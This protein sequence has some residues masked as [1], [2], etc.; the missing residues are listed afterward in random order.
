MTAP[1]LLRTERLT[2]RPFQDSD[3]E[4]ALS[5]R[6]DPEFARFLPHIPQ[7]FTRRDADRET[8][9]AAEHSAQPEML[10]DTRTPVCA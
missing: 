4:D 10:N 2:L 1:I 5:Y 6:D 7:P 8:I 9:V 3:V